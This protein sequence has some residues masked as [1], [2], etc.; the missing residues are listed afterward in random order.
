MTHSKGFGDPGQQED[1]T[2]RLRVMHVFGGHVRSGVESVV[3]DLADGLRRAG[4]HSILVPHNEGPFADEARDLGYEVWPLGKKHRYDLARIPA[5]VR[6]IK[7]GKIDILHSHAINGAFYACPAGRLA[8]STPQICSFHADTNE[9]LRDVYPS[10]LPRII[11]HRYFLLLSRLCNGLIATSEALRSSLVSDGI[12]PT[13][14]VSIS[15][16][17]DVNH[18]AH[19]T[20][21]RDAIRAELGISADTKLIGTV[22]RLAAVKD[23]P[24]FLQ[25]SRLLLEQH[26]NLRIVIAGDGP[27]RDALEAMASEMGLASRVMF[28]GWRNDPAEFISALDFF[29]LT[30][31]SETG[32]L[33]SLGAMATGIPVVSTDVGIMQ[34]FDEFRQAGMI[35]PCRDSNAMAQAVESLLKDQVKSTAAGNLGREIVQR[36]F[37]KEIMVR[38]T[39]EYYA[40]VLG[41]DA[42]HQASKSKSDYTSQTSCEAHGDDIHSQNYAS[43]P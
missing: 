5:M 23:L 36:H 34:E 39:L 6:L 14:I 12:P 35:V 25:V 41:K 17:I 15:N 22:T 20:K 38:R 33:T 43:R 42:L 8:G 27:D 30:S 11:S 7:R 19:A 9:H 37:T 4:G 24:M 2:N 40:S 28:V 16:G 21:Q 3:L 29:L 32:P 1:D 31:L 26:P 18:Y 13:K 10:S